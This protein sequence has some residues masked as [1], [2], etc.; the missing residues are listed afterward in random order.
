MP[1]RSTNVLV[2]L[3]LL[4]AAAVFAGTLPVT[5]DLGYQPTVG[6]DA[7][8]QEATDAGKEIQS[9]RSSLDQFVGGIIA[10]ASTITAMLG[11]VVAGPQMLI[12]LGAPAALVTFVAAPLYIYVGL[13]LLQVL[14]GRDIV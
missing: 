12:N 6:G 3:V 1:L 7:E 13:D 5:D 10:A 14:S 9:E 11:V 4:N 2:V 8:I